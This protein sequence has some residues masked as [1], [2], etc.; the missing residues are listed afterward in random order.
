[1]KLP[2]YLYPYRDFIERNRLKAEGYWGSANFVVETEDNIVVG[3]RKMCYGNL[4]LI[5]KKVPFPIM[6][7]YPESIL[8]DEMCQ[9]IGE[10][11]TTPLPRYY[12]WLLNESPFS[13]AYITKSASF[14]M[15]NFALTRT[16]IPGNFMLSALI[17]GRFPWERPYH[18]VMWNKLVSRGFDGTLAFLI[19]QSLACDHR[20]K[21]SIRNVRSEHDAIDTTSMDLGD[22][23]RFVNKQYLERY[24]KYEDVGTYVDVFGAWHN[25]SKI[26]TEAGF[27]SFHALLSDLVRSLPKFRTVCPLSSFESSHST[28]PSDLEAFFDELIEAL[29]GLTSSNGHQ[30]VEAA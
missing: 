1:M 29:P 7:F 21:V 17:A 8:S 2:Q 18:F 13:S 10:N 27:T 20:R 4:K 22:I 30:A 11:C 19:S 16:D 23:A 6:S 24:K 26:N 28:C 25:H 12:R 15:K 14:I 9:A 3:Q 5:R